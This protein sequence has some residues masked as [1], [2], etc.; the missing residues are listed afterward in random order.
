MQKARPPPTRPHAQL[1]IRAASF[2]KN[3]NDWGEDEDPW[4]SGS[5]N[6]SPKVVAASVKPQPV[7]GNPQRKSSTSSIAFSFI[8][9]PSSSSYPPKNPIPPP[10]TTN[11]ITT[12]TPLNRPHLTQDRT[13]TGSGWTLVDS[14]VDPKLNS[15]H[16][17]D[18]SPPD[19]Q[20]FDPDADLVLGTLDTEPLSP[21]IVEQ[22]DQLG[23]LK[24]GPSKKDILADAA[25]IV[26]GVFLHLYWRLT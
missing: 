17:V 5:D 20:P 23:S 13:R 4:D 24:L 9:A 12:P 7:P 26:D 16:V 1:N 14:D 2:N 21:S 10:A 8:H 25:K 19:K 6:D 18:E 3:V 15:E 22:A 11:T